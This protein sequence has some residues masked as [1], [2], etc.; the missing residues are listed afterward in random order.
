MYILIEKNTYII[1]SSC[2][3][4]TTGLY[5]NYFR[6]SGGVTDSRKERHRGNNIIIMIYRSHVQIIS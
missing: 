1:C 6:D 2:D 3:I 5:D 4:C